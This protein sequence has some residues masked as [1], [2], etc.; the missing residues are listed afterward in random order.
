MERDF[1]AKYP[2]V[3]VDLTPG[4]EMY[5]S[6]GKDPAYFREFFTRYADRI[7]YGTDCS[8][9]NTVEGNL[10]TCD[11]VYEFL[12]TDWNFNCWHYEFRGLNLDKPVQEKILAGNFLRR[13]SEKPKP[14]NKEALKA[15][16]NK[17]RYLIRDAQVRSLIDAELNQM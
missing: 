10:K 3:N 15:Y 9:H 11:P 13:I 5:G 16:V 6:F 17:Y 1:F 12:T 7:E 14:I 4:V 2:N 8:N